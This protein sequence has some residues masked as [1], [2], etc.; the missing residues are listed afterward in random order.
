MARRPRS[1]HLSDDEL[2]LLVEENAPAAPALAHVAACTECA[3]RVSELRANRALLASI[4]GRRLVPQH[5]VA[6]GAMLRLRARHGVIGNMNEVLA[7]FRAIVRG[8][9]ELLGGAA[10]GHPPD[11]SPQ[12]EG[13]PHG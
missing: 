12:D 11:P 5:D 10:A 3:A 13:Q 1:P 7:A 2:L 6:R 8:M 4:A 9:T